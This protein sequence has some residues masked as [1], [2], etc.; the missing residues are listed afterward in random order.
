MSISIDT[1]VKKNDCFQMMISFHDFE[2]ENISVIVECDV[3]AISAQKIC[4]TC[5]YDGTDSVI[6]TIR[7]GKDLD[8]TGLNIKWTSCTCMLI[9][10]PFKTCD[11]CGCNEPKC[12]PCCKPKCCKPKPDECCKPKKCPDACK[13]CC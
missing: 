2:R 6:K 12:V 5:D 8:P 4:K 7:L 1:C 10:A 13:N 11:P 3:I 9:T